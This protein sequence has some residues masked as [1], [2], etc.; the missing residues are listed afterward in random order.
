LGD[1]AQKRDALSAIISRM[2][3]R[4]LGDSDFEPIFQEACTAFDRD[5]FPLYRVG[6]STRTLHPLISGQS[7]RW[8]RSSDIET[9]NFGPEG[10]LAADWL[11]SPFYKM[12]EVD[13]ATFARYRI[14]DDGPQGFPVLE[15]LAAGGATDYVAYMHGFI[16][17]PLLAMERQ[18]GM[19]SSYATDH[20]NGY[21]DEALALLN[22][23]SQRMALCTKLFAR[24]IRA[25]NILSAYLGGSAGQSVLDGH[26][27]LGETQRI[28]AA[29]WFSDM[30]RSTP[31]AE[32]LGPEPFL[33]LL[34]DY[35]EVTAGT[36]LQ[37]GGEVLRF[38]GD[39]VLAIFRIDD[40]TT[41]EQATVNA[42][43]AM[44]SCLTRLE[45]YKSD[46]PGSPMEIGIGLHK[47]EV[48]FGNIGVKERL[49]FSVIGPAANE[50]ARVEGLTRDLGETVLLSDDFVQHL[51]NANGLRRIED[52]ELR[53][54]GRKFGL[55]GLSI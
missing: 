26:I 52:Q 44:R 55:W 22:R 12:L 32:E 42:M 5:V 33:A 53:G 38:I 30:R 18:D 51:P 25:E 9:D 47:G 24:E 39:A 31:L 11:A 27:R 45:T 46:N 37:T 8:Y 10:S 35:F 41:A 48:L 23:F 3:E 28:E 50:S 36:I 13:H 2:M 19:I 6:V 14:L 1:T 43:T 15:D 16:A 7:F 21:S 29:I 4:A 40:D 17:P 54:V 20:P 34:N 49:E